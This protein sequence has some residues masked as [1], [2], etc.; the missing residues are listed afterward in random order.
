VHLPLARWKDGAALGRRRGVLD[1]RE[2]FHKI[3]GCRDLW[4]LQAV[5]DEKQFSGREQLA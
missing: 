5:V 2:E 4:M 3:H 1:H